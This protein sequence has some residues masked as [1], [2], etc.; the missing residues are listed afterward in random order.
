MKKHL[1]ISDFISEKTIL[2]IERLFTKNASLDDVYDVISKLMTDDGYKE[3]DLGTNRMIF[4]PPKSLNRKDYVVKIAVDRKGQDSNF[5]EFYNGDLDKRLTFSYAVSENGTVLIQERVTPFDSHL[6]KEHKNEVVKLLKKLSKKILLVDCK[7]ENFKNF[8]FR[9]NGDV[10]LLDHGDTIPLQ[11]YQSSNIVDFEQESNVNLTC[12]RK[13]YKSYDKNNDKVKFVRVCNGKLEYDPTFSHLICTNCKN[14]VSISEC[15]MDQSIRNGTYNTNERTRGVK[16]TFD[17][18]SWMAYVKEYAKAQMT[19]EKGEC[20]MKKLSPYEM[21]EELISIEATVQKQKPKKPNKGLIE[22][23]IPYIVADELYWLPVSLTEGKDGIKA[24]TCRIENDF[25]EFK[26]FMHSHGYNISNYT[27]TNDDLIKF[28]VMEDTT[29]DVISNIEN[30]SQPEIEDEIIDEVIDDNSKKDDIV[31]TR[32]PKFS[33]SDA[34]NS[35]DDENIV[36]VEDADDDDDNDEVPNK[37]KH[38]KVNFNNITRILAKVIKEIG[39][40]RVIFS[41]KEIE[42]ITGYRID[43]YFNAIKLHRE[44][45]I[46]SIPSRFEMDKKTFSLENI[47]DNRKNNSGKTVHYCDYVECVIDPDDDEDDDI[48]SY[49]DDEDEDNLSHTNNEYVHHFDEP[50]TNISTIADSFESIIDHAKTDLTKLD[51]VIIEFDKTV[52]V[53]HNTKKIYDKLSESVD[54]IEKLIE[55]LKV[56]DDAY[57]TMVR[58]QRSLESMKIE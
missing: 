32:T 31:I 8:G 52:P 51:K 24:R 17:S 6:M 23:C 3:Y 36:D 9:K 5:R 13:F 47:V 45:N 48:L 19:D 38:H 56:C 29:M 15:Y 21:Y 25:G 40:Y 14:I 16:A 26:N 53:Y 35:D 33:E 50:H 11:K 49:S 34:F 55:A 57:Q 44:L 7:L 41:F 18:K 43:N 20:T 58:V 4:L 46:A 1:K 42:T 22:S 39:E 27:M 2:R 12:Q 37:K 10:V 30:L 54:K 28:G